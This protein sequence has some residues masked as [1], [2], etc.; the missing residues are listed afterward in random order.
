LRSHPQAELKDRSSPP[1]DVR[2]GCRDI[3]IQ[4]MLSQDEVRH[5]SPTLRSSKVFVPA[6]SETGQPFLCDLGIASLFPMNAMFSQNIVHHNK[7]YEN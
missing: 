2:R 5:N 3:R 7:S 6:R 1:S 4:K